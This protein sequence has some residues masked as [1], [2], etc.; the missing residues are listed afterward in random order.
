MVARP[1]RAGT[2]QRPEIGHAFHHDDDRGI[3]PRVAADGAGILRIEVA[4]IRAGHDPLCRHAHGIGQRRQQ[5]LRLRIRCSTARRA[6]R[7]PRPGIRARSWISRSISGPASD[8]AI[9]ASSEGQLEAGWQ[10][11]ATHQALRL[12][13]DDLLH[14]G[15]RIL[16]RRHHEIFE[17]FRLVRVH[18]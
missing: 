2:L 6:E 13:G 8:C 11:Q 18:Q 15:P 4:T 1:H 7:G 5:F 9:T 3:S 16:M 14:L 17:D 10:W 12:V